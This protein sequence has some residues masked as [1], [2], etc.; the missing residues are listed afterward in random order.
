V[1][2][3]AARAIVAGGGSLLPVGV[4]EIRGEF[5]E[6]AAVEVLDHEGSLIAKGLVTLS[7]TVL[8]PLL[9]RHSSAITVDGWGGEVI[10]RDD[11]VVLAG[12]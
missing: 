7:S 2:A 1:D 5:A 9:G 12:S 10:H 11:L 4:T 6:G 3:G 8:A